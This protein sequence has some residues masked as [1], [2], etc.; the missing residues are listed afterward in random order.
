VR[1]YV[2]RWKLFEKGCMAKA[3]RIC[4]PRPSA[5]NK[6]IGLSMERVSMERVSMERVSME[7]VSMERVSTERVV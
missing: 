5:K 7:R 2:V 4:P 3:N 6:P 1:L